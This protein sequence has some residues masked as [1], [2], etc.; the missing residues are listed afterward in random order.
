MVIGATL[1]STL[2]WHEVVTEPTPADRAASRLILAPTYADELALIAMVQQRVQQTASIYRPIPKGQTREPADLIAA[3]QGLCYDN[4]RSIEKLLEAIG[5]ETRHVAL[6]I[7]AAAV[8]VPGSK[9]HAM[10][11]VLTSRGWLLV[12]STTDWI[13]LDADGAPVSA[14]Q[15]SA[16]GGGTISWREP[17]PEKHWMLLG[18][19]MHVVGLYS[20]HG[21]FYPP[22][23]PVPDVNWRQLMM[24]VAG[25]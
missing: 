19:F 25:G 10:S 22:F 9:S 13:A 16:V 11:E 23:T 12:D 20:R 14:D 5:F 2:W 7:D 21:S 17:I 3:G 8:L 15:L 4:S 6:Y 24:N 18:D 1:I